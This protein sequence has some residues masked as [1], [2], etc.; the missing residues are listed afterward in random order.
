MVA[1]YAEQGLNVICVATDQGDYE[2]DDSA[3]VSLCS[4]R[5]DVFTPKLKIMYH[6]IGRYSGFLKMWR[7]QSN[8]GRVRR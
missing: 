6:K 8:S 5:E 4:S 7:P 1:K 2:P 3:T